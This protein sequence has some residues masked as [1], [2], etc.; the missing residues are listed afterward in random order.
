MLLEERC[1]L[2]AHLI[3]SSFFCLMQVSTNLSA[4]FCKVIIYSAKSAHGNKAEQK[5]W[6]IKFHDLNL[7]LFSSYC[8]VKYHPANADGAMQRD[9]CFKTA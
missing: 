8:A 5:G 7:E 1:H 4:S 9:S 6:K 3:T 2:R